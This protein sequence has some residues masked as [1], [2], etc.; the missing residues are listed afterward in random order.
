MEGK[1]TSKDRLKCPN[2]PN[3]LIIG[4]EMIMGDKFRTFKC[5]VCNIKFELVSKGYLESL[6]K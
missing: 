6:R 5:I 1:L 4:E 2:C 3:N